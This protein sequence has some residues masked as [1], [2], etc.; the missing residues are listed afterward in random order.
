M[1]VDSR[2]QYERELAPFPVSDSAGVL[3]APFLGGI[4]S[5]KPAL[6]DLDGDGALD[7]FIA[8][9][10]GKITHVKNIGTPQ[11]PQW[12][13]FSER[14]GGVDAGSWFLLR[15]IDA[16]GD[17]D[18]FCDARN[19]FTA[20]YENSASGDIPDFTLITTTYSGFQ[21]GF[22]NTPAFEDIDFDGDF[23]FFFGNQGGGLDF[24]RNIGD[25][26]NPL[27]DTM[28][29][30]YDDVFAFPGGG[31]SLGRGTGETGESQA[32]H[33]FS[34]LSFADVDGDYDLDL[35]YGDIFNTSAYFFENLGNAEVSDLRILSE[36]FLPFSTFA[37]N[38]AAFGD[39]DDD[40]DQ[41]M[42]VGA[43]NA[44]DLNN[45]IYLRN[46]SD[47][48]VEILDL[49][50]LIDR[51]YIKQLDV[52]S[53]AQP[54]FGDIDADGDFDLLIGGLN[55]KIAHYENTGSPESPELQFRSGQFQGVNTV[56]AAIPVLVDWDNDSDL[57]LLVGTGAG[58]VQQW[59]NGGDSATMTLV[60]G[61]D[62][63]DASAT[64]KVDQ[65]AVP[66][67]GDWN[68]D[69]KLDL[70]LGEWDF[71]SFANLLIYQNTGTPSSPALTLITNRALNREF[72]LLTIPN[73]YDWDADGRL[74][75]LLSGDHFGVSVKLNLAEANTF[76]D[77]FSL[78]T[79]PAIL[80]GYDDGE[81]LSYVFV[82]I[83][84]DGDDDLFV[85]EEDG[86]INFYR[87]TNSLVSRG[88]VDGTPGIGAS[89][90]TFL[91]NFLF[92]NGPAPQPDLF[93]AD[94]D[95]SGAIDLADAIRLLIYVY[96]SGPAPCAR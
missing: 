29:A 13:V 56:Q 24:Y 64:I 87:H 75:L 33:G 77:S 36:S 22:N 25:S 26:A 20:F 80:P 32:L 44:E 70:I 30:D 1:S 23:D 96:A 49:Y 48:G 79:A 92:L 55:G 90:V 53:N 31:P 57:D 21:T 37:F 83:D 93:L 9:G 12:S 47:T 76:P 81:R 4:N 94:V 67:V 14:L 71:N 27:F 38:H 54:V 50:T 43:A 6:A 95:C 58:R 89:D 69:H 46:E 66:R 73:L 86:G 74:D 2:A 68:G 10:R 17:L 91:I 78:Y 60:R 19:S 18:L 82:D 61:P 40:G 72:K 45:L 3:V 11:I 65:W 16:D 5:P 39:L 15:D 51:N 62:L 85:G 7:L 34:A 63:A 52:G 41:D 8:D 28:I 59:I 84:N 88:D 35:F 42:I